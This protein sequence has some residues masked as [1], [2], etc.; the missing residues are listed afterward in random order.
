[1]NIVLTGGT[2]LIGKS[3]IA[4]LLENGHSVVALT[5]QHTTAA[6]SAFEK[7]PF[8]TVQWDAHTLGSG[9][10]AWSKEISGA[11]A[12]IHLAGE[13]IFDKRWTAEIKHRLVESRLTTTRL[14]VEA[15]AQA[16]TKPR[17]FISASAVGYYGDRHDVPT[18]ESTPPATDFLADLCVRWEKEAEE[19][20]KYGVRVANPRLGIVLAESGGALGRMLPV[21]KAFLGMPLG[22]GKQWFPWVHSEDVVRGICFPLENSNLEGAYNLASPA[23]VRMEEFC[24]E[25]GKALNRPSWSP[26]SVPEFAL[27]LALGEAA[28]SLTGGANIIPKKLLELHFEFRYTKVSSALQQLLRP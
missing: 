21:F 6:F 17:V 16:D 15:I 26:L 28:S 20:R 5:R 7:K 2:G 8:R 10:R 24:A 25:L 3:V 22:A 1:M 11:E 18:D 9:D 23:P 19:A 14:L 12:I 4:H 27:K 13:G